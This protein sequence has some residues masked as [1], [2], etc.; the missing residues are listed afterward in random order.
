MGRE[1]IYPPPPL[2]NV[3][4]VRIGV[5]KGTNESMRWLYGPVMHNDWVGCGSAHLVVGCIVA[6]WFYE[7]CEA[8]FSS[9]GPG[10]HVIALGGHD[11]TRFLSS[12]ESFQPGS[13]QWQDLEEMVDTRGHAASCVLKNELWVL[14]GWDPYDKI[15]MRREDCEEKAL[16]SVEIFN[17]A[18]GRWRTGVALAERRA[19]HRAAV[20]GDS[21][22]VVGGFDGVRDLDTVSRLDMVERGEWIMETPLAH[23]RSGLGIG[24][25]RGR[26]YVMGGHN[27]LECLV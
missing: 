3:L 15:R 23:P 8:D 5:S 10:S 25:V 22:Y 21:V 27:G 12:A 16:K 18:T 6:L 14:G 2:C 7:I 4:E 11:G 19:F 17:P 26:I 9:V 20:L 1:S 13:S 24:V